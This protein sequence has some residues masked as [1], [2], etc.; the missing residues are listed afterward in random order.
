MTLPALVIYCC[1]KGVTF[2]RRLGRGIWDE[3]C[4]WASKSCWPRYRR[5]TGVEKV[6]I[7]R[8]LV[9]PAGNLA[10]V[11]KSMKA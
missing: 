6:W 4:A 10:Q 3:N 9:Y 1:T 2:S 11:G 8:D 5:S 7:E